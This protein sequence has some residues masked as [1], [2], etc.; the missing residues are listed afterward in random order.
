[1]A[2]ALKGREKEGKGGVSGAT[3]ALVAAEDGYLSLSAIQTGKAALQLRSLKVSVPGTPSSLAWLPV[4][5]ADPTSSAAPTVDRSVQGA[6]AD[7]VLGTSTGTLVTVDTALGEEVARLSL[8]SDSVASLAAVSADLVAA[9]CFD[10]S[11]VLVDVAR[12]TVTARL[13]HGAPVHA[14]EL[15]A[16]D[17]G[18]STLLA[19][20]GS[21][22]IR[23]WDVGTRRLVTQ[24]TGPA[25]TITCLSFDAARGLLYAGSL[26]GSVRVYETASWGCADVG[27]K[28]MR[29]PAAVLSLAVQ[30]STGNV[31]AVGLASGLVAVT[32]RALSALARLRAT[33]RRLSLDSG[34]YRHFLQTSGSP[35]D[36][37]VVEPEQRRRRRLSP[38]AAAL[39]RFEH[40]EALALAVRS[41]SVAELATVVRELSIRGVLRQAVGQ[42]DDKGVL[43]L[44]RAVTASLSLPQYAV[45]T[46]TLAHA[47]LDVYGELAAESPKVL[48]A[49]SSLRHSVSAELEVQRDVQR[50]QGGIEWIMSSR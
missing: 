34:A 2:V 25:K 18:T 47:V 11:V 5:T 3:V 26:D 16:S 28:P 15:L 12:A 39:G 8:A 29:F 32:E 40:R 31:L 36:F 41:G 38:Y 10:G 30:R 14:L 23:I 7:A 33:K 49:L 45:T 50:C 43:S 6:R 46:L 1:V 4:P 13:E 35:G 37:V 9:G 21:V 24:L 48:A 27:G 42:R 17:T 22:Y 20:A 19:S 44:L